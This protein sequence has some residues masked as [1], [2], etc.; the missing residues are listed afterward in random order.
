M[1][2]AM[3]HEA[4]I[5]R[6]VRRL[7]PLFMIAAL[8]LGLLGGLTPATAAQ[9]ATPAQIRAKIASLAVSQVGKRETGTNYYPIAYKTHSYIIRPAAWCGIFSHWAWYKGGATRRPNMTGSGTAQG[10]WAT[11]WQKWGQ[12]NRRWKPISQRKVA[13]GDVVVYGNYPRSAHVGVVVDV[14]YSSSGR[15]TSVR[16]VEGNLSNKVTNTG[17]RSITRLTGGGYAA[18]G[19]VSPV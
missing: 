13:K 11:Y 14:R 7:G 4:V 1:E 10:H 12:N 6:S 15:A 8:A 17:W 9:A 5:G 19:F 18:T 16:T 2:G 3:T